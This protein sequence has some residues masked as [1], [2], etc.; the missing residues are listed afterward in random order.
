MHF[1]RVYNIQIFQSN[2][3]FYLLQRIPTAFVVH[4]E[5]E[6]AD[7]ATLRRSSGDRWCTKIVKGEEG[8]SL[9]NGWEKFC[10]DNNLAQ[11]DV[12]LFQYCGNW[13]LDVEIFGPDGLEKW[14]KDFGE[15]EKGIKQRK[16][17]LSHYDEQRNKPPVVTNKIRIADFAE[18]E[19]DPSITRKRERKPRGE[20]FLAPNKKG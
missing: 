10:E 11:G 14:M 7:T 12:L 19:V 15:V 9:E 18:N 1:F 3:F 4:M 2:Y 5:E 6:V 13:C 8:I 20:N 17:N 16:L